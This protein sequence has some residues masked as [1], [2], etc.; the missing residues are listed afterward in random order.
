MGIVSRTSGHP[1]DVPF[2]LEFWWGTYGLGAISR[3]RKQILAIAAV[4]NTAYDITS[5]FNITRKVAARSLSDYCSEFTP[6]IHCNPLMPRLICT[7]I[8]HLSSRWNWKKTVGSR[9]ACFV[10][11][12][13]ELTNRPTNH[14]LK[15][16]LE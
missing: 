3:R 1:K 13:P 15:S 11:G 5:R 6:Q 9:W 8:P 2:V 7:S 14:K 10:S 4:D 12:F 16:A